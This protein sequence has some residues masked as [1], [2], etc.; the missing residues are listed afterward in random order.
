MVQADL[1]FSIYRGTF[2]LKMRALNYKQSLFTIIF[3]GF[4]EP[5][6]IYKIEL[7]NF[8]V[9]TVSASMKIRH[10]VARGV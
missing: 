6:F 7:R 1:Q 9:F 5:F 10:N 4:N 8:I 3:C 2:L